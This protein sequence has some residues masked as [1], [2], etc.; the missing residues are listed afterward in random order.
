MLQIGIDVYW[1][2]RAAAGRELSVCK[3]FCLSRNH[4]QAFLWLLS[5]TKPVHCNDDDLRTIS[6][7]AV[8]ALPLLCSALIVHN[9]LKKKRKKK[10]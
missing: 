7:T 9:F 1:L 2:K 8:L 4:F 5:A 3:L 6:Q 10:S